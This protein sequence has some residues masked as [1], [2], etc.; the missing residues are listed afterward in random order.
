MLCQLHLEP[1]VS[2]LSG[3]EGGRE[4]GRGE[5][6]TLM[7]LNPRQTFFPDSRQYETKDNW[8]QSG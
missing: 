3:R 8:T 6:M 2:G 5:R 4:E 1:S 7:Y